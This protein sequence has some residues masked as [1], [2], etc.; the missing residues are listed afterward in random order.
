MKSACFTGHRKIK[1][2]TTVLEKNFMMYW[3]II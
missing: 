1:E 3:K 2:D